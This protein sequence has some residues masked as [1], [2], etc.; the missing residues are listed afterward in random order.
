MKHTQ[1]ALTDGAKW[2]FPAGCLGVSSWRGLCCGQ[3]CGQGGTALRHARVTQ[4]GDHYF[5]HGDVL[6][7]AHLHLGA[8]MEVLTVL[9]TLAEDVLCGPNLKMPFA[10]SMGCW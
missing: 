1:V 5:L 7:L 6:L 9:T 8:G 3:G 2:E 10:S 4:Q